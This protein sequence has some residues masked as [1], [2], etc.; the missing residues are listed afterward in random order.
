MINSGIVVLL[1]FIVIE[2][3]LYIIV[4]VFVFCSVLRCVLCTLE[5]H[6][7]TGNAN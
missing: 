6:P 7:G 1:Y 2:L 3:V 5:V 4:I